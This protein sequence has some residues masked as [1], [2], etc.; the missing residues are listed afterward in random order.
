MAGTFG[1]FFNQ[2]AG[3]LIG[4]AGGA[5]VGYLLAPEKLAPIAAVVGA[6]G[7]GVTGYELTG[8]LA[9]GFSTGKI[10]LNNTN[11]TVYG[12]TYT[13]SSFTLIGT[14]FSALSTINIYDELGDLLNTTS[15]GPL[16]NISVSTSLQSYRPQPGSGYIYAL[17]TH[18]GLKSNKVAV[19]YAQSTTGTS[20]GTGTS[21]TGGTGTI[22]PLI[23]PALEWYTGSTTGWINL[24]GYGFTPGGKV[25]IYQSIV[26]NGI[27][28]QVN[29]FGTVAALV[30]S[31]TFYYPYTL[32]TSEFLVPNVA[33][34]TGEGIT[35]NQ[36]YAVDE[37]TGVQSGILTI[38]VS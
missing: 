38:S 23:S 27:A 28:T 21:T 7:G 11:F 5:T 14:G 1:G 25:T 10:S 26:I 34:S 8:M 32:H 29:R 33:L 6:V 17:D 13:P 37:S 22:L 31:L 35:A 2:I 36:F 19:A 20:Q 4:V 12:D 15:S 16:G 30:G 24:F 18:T 9:G 3:A